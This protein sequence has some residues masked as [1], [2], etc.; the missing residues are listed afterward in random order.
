M[1]NMVKMSMM[2]AMMKMRRLNDVEAGG[3]AEDVEVREDVKDAEDGEHVKDA[4][5]DEDATT[6]S[7]RSLC[8]CYRR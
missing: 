6:Y 4:E 2:P 5:H 8:L 3:G 1:Q 7:C